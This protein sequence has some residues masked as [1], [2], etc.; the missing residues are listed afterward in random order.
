MEEDLIAACGIDCAACDLRRVP[1]DSAAASRVVE[2]FRGKG[3]IG[4]TD[5]QAEIIA[6]SMYCRGCRVDRAVHWSPDCFILKC[7]VDDRGLSHC[8]QCAGFPCEPLRDWS[9]RSPKYTAALA[10]L[11]RMRAS[12]A[13]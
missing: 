1:F 8:D 3:W 13:P 9:R 5:G 4:P 12:T 10:R 11:T 2:W 6:R 7:C